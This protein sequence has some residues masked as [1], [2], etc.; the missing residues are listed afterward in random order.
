MSALYLLWPDVPIGDP[1]ALLFWTV[2]QHPAD[3]PN[4]WVVR[5]SWYNGLGA[6]AE[7]QT[8]KPGEVF[9]SHHEL[10]FGPFGIGPTLEQVR[11]LIPPGLYRMPRQPDD[12]PAIYEVWF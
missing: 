8:P 6:G 2:Y 1:S 4:S 12:D 11:L 3:F 9:T 7:R 5:P 10:Q